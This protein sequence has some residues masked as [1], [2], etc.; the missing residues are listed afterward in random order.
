MAKS[1]ACR[2]FIGEQIYRYKGAAMRIRDENFYTVLGWM[3]NVLELKGNELIVFAIVYSFSQDGVS[4]FAGSLS[5]M[6]TFANIKSQ[7]TVMT[8][9]KALQEKN[10]ILK[11]EYMKDNVRRIAYRV[12]FEYI[13]QLLNE[14]AAQIKPNNHLKN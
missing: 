9:L 4:E 6:Q 8:N 10:F 5:Y 13:D 3:L 1:H 7:N 12:N 14:K 11:R 2:C